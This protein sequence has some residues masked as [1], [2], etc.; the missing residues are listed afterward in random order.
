MRARLL[1]VPLVLLSACATVPPEAGFPDVAAKVAASEGAAPRWNRNSAEDAEAARAVEALL[2]PD[3]GGLGAEAAV[4]VALL[5]N[6]E[7]Q[8]IYEDLGVS[9][10]EV[11]RAGLLSNPVF[12]GYVRFPTKG[13]GTNV[14]VEAAQDFLQIFMLPARKRL[15]ATQFEAVKARV[16]AQVLD[17]AAQVRA[18][19]FA[20]TAAE[21]VARVRGL[22]AQAARLNYEY[23]LRLHTAGNASE[24]DAALLRDEWE[25]TRVEHAKALAQAQEARE[26]LLA[27]MGLW[28]PHAGA[29]GTPGAIVLAGLPEVPA[30]ELTAEDLAGLE[31]LAIERRP[32][33]AAAKLQAEAAAQALRTT[34]DWRWLG[35][36]QVGV[37]AERDPTPRG[38]WLVG[39]SFSLSLP[40]L[41]QGQTAVAQEQALL[42]QSV[43]QVEALAVAAR[44]QVRLARDRLLAARELA[45]HLKTVVIPQRERTVALWQQQYNYMLKGLPEVLR[46]RQQEYAAYEDYLLAVRDYWTA[47]AD[48]KLAVGGRMP[49]GLP[50]GPEAAGPPVRTE[51]EVRDDGMH[52]DHGGMPM[53]DGMQ[54]HGASM[55][56]GSMR[57]DH[58]SMHMDHGGM[59]MPGMAPEQQ[60]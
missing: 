60:H 9:Q 19:H 46:A 1:L 7:L 28:G 41:D 35:T 30:A 56:H 15:A 27:A 17:K 6:P 59:D 40:L 37:N 18:A 45:L 53:H 54:M 57:M 5:D 25:R 16:T 49:H 42:R 39:P 24:L 11:V 3:A 12:G 10:A 44:S 2:F 55:D 43:R 21:G 31:T 14:E 34:L 33:V 51:P 38:S 47:W 48:L 32:D 36:A 50:P 20:A 58:G 4:Q 8:A 22:V 52:M 29:A 26:A 13:P 23:L